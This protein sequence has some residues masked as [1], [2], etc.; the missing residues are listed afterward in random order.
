MCPF[1]VCTSTLTLTVLK[2]KVQ[3]VPLRKE[4]RK[5]VLQTI[6]ERMLDVFRGEMKTRGW[7][8]CQ[9]LGRSGVTENP[10]I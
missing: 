7:R 10:L 6:V 3:G 4:P 9:E 2:H 8:R 1:W 5:K